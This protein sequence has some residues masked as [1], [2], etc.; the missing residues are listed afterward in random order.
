[1]TSTWS[2]YNKRDRHTHKKWVRTT[3]SREQRSFRT[4]RRAAAIIGGAA[5]HLRRRPV[6]LHRWREGAGVGVDSWRF[7][8]VAAKAAEEGA[9]DASVPLLLQTAVGL[10]R[11]QN[12]R[13]E[14]ERAAGE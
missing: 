8:I 1:M 12:R 4:I 10:G 5:A 9:E 3:N 2:H 7:H 6:L 11:C 14:R 13:Q